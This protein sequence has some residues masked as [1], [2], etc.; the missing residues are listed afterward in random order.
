MIAAYVFAN[1]MLKKI[2][3][4]Q[5]L[6]IKVLLCILHQKLLRFEALYFAA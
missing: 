6:Q 3:I 4:F 2:R 5:Q 1:S